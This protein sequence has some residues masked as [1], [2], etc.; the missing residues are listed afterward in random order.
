MQ[1]IGNMLAGLE[2][3]EG[4]DDLGAYGIRLA[5]CGRECRRRMADQAVLDF[6]GTDAVARGRDHVVVP[7]GKV[8]LAA[9]LGRRWS[10]N[11]R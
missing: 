5:N 7:A 10:S 2:H 6:A 9:L 1:R 11:R 8:E 3:Y 4:L